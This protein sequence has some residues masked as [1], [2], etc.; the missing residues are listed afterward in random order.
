MM[1]NKT[2]NLFERL[3][4]FVLN[5]IVGQLKENIDKVCFSLICKRLYNERNRYLYI[6]LDMSDDRSRWMISNLKLNSY[7]NQIETYD[8]FDDEHYKITKFQCFDSK[9][10]LSTFYKK[11]LGTDS[12]PRFSNWILKENDNVDIKSLVVNYNFQGNICEIPCVKRVDTLLFIYPC[13]TIDYRLPDN[14]KQMVIPFQDQEHCFGENAC[15]PRQLDFLAIKCNQKI[16]KHFLPSSLSNLNL[17]SHDFNHPIDRDVLPDGLKHLTLIAGH[18]AHPILKGVLPT[19]L[20]SLTLSSYSGNLVFYD[21]LTLN[22]HDDNNNNNNNNNNYDNNNDNHNNTYI[23]NTLEKLMIGT[24]PALM[25]TKFNEILSSNLKTI[26]FLTNFS[27]FIDN[28][29]IPPSVTKLHLSS[30]PQAGQPLVIPSG[31]R[32]LKISVLQSMIPRDSI[33]D[34]LEK[35][36]ILRLNHQNSGGSLFQSVLTPTFKSE[37]STIVTPFECI[38]PSIRS[39]KLPLLYCLHSDLNDI[40]SNIQNITFVDFAM[41]KI[42]LRRLDDQQKFLVMTPMNQG[43]IILSISKIIEMLSNRYQIERNQK[44]IWNIEYLEKNNIE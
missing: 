1:N 12:S 21:P 42:C 7:A 8:H 9:E 6:P 2:L 40:P 17:F 23:P 41:E 43:G 11:S 31:I 39:I 22:H 34:S 25:D 10:S 44:N 3:P 28:N 13:E 38:T 37:N 36:S 5:K 26:G 14:I 33:P 30:Y 20:K 18:Y 32:H 24:P 19:S 15:L 27:Q 29:M 16:Q 35:L 4:F